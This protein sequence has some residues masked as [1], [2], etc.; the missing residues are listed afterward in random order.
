MYA[1]VRNAAI[2]QTGH[3][4]DTWF[5]GTRW[6]DFRTEQPDPSTGWLPIADTTRPADPT[7]AYDRSTQLVN[8]TPT[9]VWT[10]RNWTAEEQAARTA[11]TNDKTIRERAD[12]ALTTNAN[13]LALATPTNA[14]VVAH[15]RALT[16]Q[17]T[18]LI[19]LA[20]GQ[21]DSTDGT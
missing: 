18:G 7:Y 8:G 13:F 11:A 12:A 20:L 9:V 5:D 21:L 15:V 4:P 6:W 10:A 17:A 1:L 14:Q 16:R 3:L 19:R 2:V